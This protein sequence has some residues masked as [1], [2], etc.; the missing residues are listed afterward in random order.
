MCC[1]ESLLR[2]VVHAVARATGWHDAKAWS[3]QPTDD[4]LLCA[5]TNQNMQNGRYSRFSTEH[6]PNT[7]C[8]IK[9]H[10][11]LNGKRLVAAST[12]YKSL[13][14]D[15]LQGRDRIFSSVSPLT[16]LFACVSAR[17]DTSPR[18]AVR[19]KHTWWTETQ[20]LLISLTYCI[21]MSLKKVALCHWRKF[22]FDRL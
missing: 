13:N 15:L 7:V 5:L 2:V 1:K 3:R 21:P 8:L 9:Y 20:R 10:Y 16:W 12:N 6:F 11:R 17:P 4:L 18:P 19:N 14:I 22:N